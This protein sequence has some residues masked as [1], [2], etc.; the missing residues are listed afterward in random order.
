MLVSAKT[1]WG[2]LAGAGGDE[3][4]IQFQNSEQRNNRTLASQLMVEKTWYIS[5]IYVKN[6]SKAVTS[7]LWTHVPKF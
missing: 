3:K 6:R 1:R 2:W 4:N 7:S 5:S